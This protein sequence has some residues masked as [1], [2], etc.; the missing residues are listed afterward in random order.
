M[1]SIN[2][3]KSNHCLEWG[4]SMGQGPS[5]YNLQEISSGFVSLPAP[6][7]PLC[8]GKGGGAPIQEISKK[9]ARM[10]KASNLDFIL[11]MFHRVDQ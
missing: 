8:K 10:G 1:F 11:W 5:T 2:N 4:S 3:K 7:P 9:R 6:P